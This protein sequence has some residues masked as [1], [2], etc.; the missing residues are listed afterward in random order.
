[1][2]NFMDGPLTW[3]LW[4]VSLVNYSLIIFTCIDGILLPAHM[5]CD[6]KDD[7]LHGSDENLCSR[8]K[9][10]GYKQNVLN[11]GHLA[12]CDFHNCSYTFKCP[13]Y[14]CV[15]WSYVCDGH[16]DCPPGL[17]EIQCVIKGKPGYLRCS[18]SS[19]AVWIKILRVLILFADAFL[20]DC[21][22]MDDE[23]WD[24][25]SHSHGRIA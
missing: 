19:W 16:W 9:Q 12:T 25:K 1:M 8:H 11:A 22:L 14:Y 21:P 2:L 6:S 20:R 17:D 18:N 24:I 23:Q 15:P 13:G 7:C 3:W 5:L 4:K 10:T